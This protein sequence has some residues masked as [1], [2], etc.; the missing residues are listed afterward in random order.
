MDR[1]IY[2]RS[3]PARN[4]L[5]PLFGCKATALSLVD[6]AQD[7]PNMELAG[8]RN[9]VPFLSNPTFNSTARKVANML[10]THAE[11]KLSDGTTLRLIPSRVRNGRVI[12]FNESN[13]PEFLL[14]MAMPFGNLLDSIQSSGVANLY[15]PKTLRV[16]EEMGYATKR[17]P[18]I[19]ELSFENASYEY[20]ERSGFD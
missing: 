17:R 14:S 15:G 9:I 5:F 4:C 1:L 18:E 16:F 20:H 19:V 2:G 12:L 6:V 10:E 7:F 8:K 13:T 11:I 3:K